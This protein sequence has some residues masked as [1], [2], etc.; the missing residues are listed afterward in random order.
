MEGGC[1]RSKY[2]ER[3]SKHMDVSNIII[4][5]IF[6]FFFIIFII[7]HELSLDRT[8]STSS[9]SLLEG[10][11]SRLRPFCLQFNSIFGISCSFLLHVA[12]NFICIF[13]VSRQ[14]VL[15]SSLPKL[16]TPFVVKKGVP[17]CSSEK[18][19]LIDVNRFYPLL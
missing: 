12:D 16:F 6:F 18:F 5:I 15:L 7:R 14:M 8:V 9:N 2:C 19:N 4:I 1:F 13:L 11:P 3:F 17:G 10:I